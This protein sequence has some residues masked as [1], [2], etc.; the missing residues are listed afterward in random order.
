MVGVATSSWRLDGV[1]VVPS[2][3]RV[4]SKVDL[5]D[6]EREEGPFCSVPMFLV[7]DW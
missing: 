5:V 3:D 2:F 1:A 7:P 6:Y 4:V